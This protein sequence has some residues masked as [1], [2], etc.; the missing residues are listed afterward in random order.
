MTKLLSTLF[1]LMGLFFAVAPAQSA[2][3]AD[4]LTSYLTLFSAHAVNDGVKLN[5]SLERQSPTLLSFRIYRGYEE[6]G[7]FAVLTDVAAGSGADSVD[8]SITDHDTRPGVSYFYK[9]AGVAQHGESIFPVVISATPAS[10]DAATASGD[11]PPVALLP[12]AKVTLYVRKAGQVR[13]EVR[14][15]PLKMLVNDQL[16]PGIYE[17]DPPRELQQN[18]RLRVT[19]ESDFFKE[20][21]WPLKP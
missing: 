17:F 4:V 12:G 3:T 7:N 18:T 2:E 21:T 11:L 16:R 6:V 5:W 8:Y 20:M 19:Y 14:G 10:P 13:L 1:F 15:T 9:I